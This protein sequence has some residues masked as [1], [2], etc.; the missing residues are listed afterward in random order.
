ML[1]VKYRKVFF[2]ISAV[3]VALSL[4][5]V[6][7]FGLNFGIDF[8]G[9]A[10]TEVRYPDGR[11]D[12]VL[13]EERLKNLSIGGFSLRPTGDDSFIL[14]T[15][16]LEEE[17]RQSVISALS[18]NGEKQLVEER[19]NSIGPVI[20]E[21]L[22]IKAVVAILVVAIAIVLFVAFVFRHVS[23]PV[24]SWKYG[25]IAIIALMHDIIVPVGVFALLGNLFGAEVNVLF[26]M[27]LL[28]ILGYSVNDTIVVFDRVRENL[29]INREQKRKE[30]FELTVGKSLNQTYTRSINTSLTTLFVL[31][32]LFFLG[33]PVTR[34]F[35]LVLL[36]GVLAG[37]YSSIF[38]AAPLLVVWGRGK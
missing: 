15:R 18:L 17:E 22:R 27:A 28:A 36:T 10:I 4:G 31:L 29:R 37:T 1:V 33:A 11:P 7:V 35:T 21:E 13:V 38:L 20:G 5:A 25:V 12:G 3:I 8:T 9:G 24:S 6:I 34:D 26:V 23:E 2:V 14:R 30:N 19:F 32:A 16:D